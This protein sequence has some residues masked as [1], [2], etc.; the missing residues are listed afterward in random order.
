MAVCSC[1][2]L[3]SPDWIGKLYSLYTCLH[4]LSV[5]S[6]QDKEPEPEAVSEA[7]GSGPA[8]E[9]AAEGMSVLS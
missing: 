1:W 8:E 3:F 4:L 2:F 7:V 5:R 6:E 9:S